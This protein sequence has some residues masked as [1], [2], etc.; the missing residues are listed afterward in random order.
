MTTSIHY[1]NGIP[2][3]MMTSAAM[4]C[5]VVLAG[6]LLCVGNVIAAPSAATPPKPTTAPSTNPAS[7]LSDQDQVEFLQKN[8]QAQMQELQDR[9]FRLAEATRATEPGDSA[10]LIMALKRSREELIL[11]EMREVLEQLNQKNLNKA[12]VNTQEV[13]IKLEKL[14]ELLLST[15]LDLQMALERIKALQAAIAKVDGAIKEEKRESANSGKMQAAAATQPVK[16]K[17]TE[18][19]KKDQ[20][21]NRKTTE[22]VQKTVKELGDPVTN[23]SPALAD[24]AQAM[25]S[26]EGQL[27]SGK[28]GD[29]QGKQNEATAALQQ[30]REQMEAERQKMLAEIE[31]LVKKQVLEN[32]ALMLEKQKAI[33]EANEALAPRLA[34]NNR[35]A[36][37]RLKTLAASET[38][39]ANMAETTAQLIEDT[40]FSFALPLNLR[41]IERRAIYITSDLNAGKGDEPVI[42]AEKKIERDLTD[43]IDTFKQQTNSSQ[44]QSR[45]KG[46][47]NDKNKLLAE[48]KAI[49]MLQVRVNEETLELEGHRANLKQLPK[50][51]QDQI[52][53]TRDHQAGVRDILDRLDATL[54]DRPP[55]Y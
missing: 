16:P 20:E 40:E 50:E 51:L 46:C 13:I 31:S 9:M 24:A 10:K 55:T 15:D 32:L 5:V 7:K 2:K 48:L 21:Q 47:K 26:A 54:T 30:A 44:G 39:I 8:V 42:I 36:V 23:A 49:R 14:K 41:N 43:L 35:E 53:E 33:R 1:D 12:V 27:G 11:E 6:L 3:S 34:Q 18:A 25:A 37:L 4:C 29:A 19:A 45:C 52:G 38:H 17:D 28:P 22:A